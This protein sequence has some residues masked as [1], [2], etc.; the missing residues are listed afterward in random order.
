MFMLWN[1]FKLKLLL[2]SQKGFWLVKVCQLERL[3]TA[4]VTIIPLLNYC[5]VICMFTHQTMYTNASILCTII[6]SRDAILQILL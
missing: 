6:I 5:T 3:L 2:N 1:S 4:W